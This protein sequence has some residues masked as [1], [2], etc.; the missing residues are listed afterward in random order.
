MYFLKD[1]GHNH[2][3][4]EV[5]RKRRP[6]DESVLDP[7]AA[8]KRN[9]STCLACEIDMFFLHY[10]S[11]SRGR[12]VVAILEELAKSPPR[13]TMT[14]FDEISSRDEG[15]KPSGEPLLIA[16][17]LHVAWKSGG[18]SHLAGYEQRDAH[19][20][21]HAFLDILGKQICQ[22]RTRVENA[23]AMS[24]CGSRFTKHNE[25]PHRH[26]K[27]RACTI[28]LHCLFVLK[29]YLSG[30]YLSFSRRH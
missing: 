28:F 9:T 4:C 2:K 7:V 23:I 3:A 14:L 26:G 17:L 11:N 13:N 30:R 29:S 8:R 27:L 25:T 18:M 15:R 16:K 21:L 1:I 5:Y 19:E 6:S 12:D 22:H 10:Y 24:R 20:F